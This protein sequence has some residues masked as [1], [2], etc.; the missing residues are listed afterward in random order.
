MLLVHQQLAQQQAARQLITNHLPPHSVPLPHGGSPHGQP[1]RESN[2]SSV[3]PMGRDLRPP[4]RD[5]HQADRVVVA[6]SQQTRPGSVHAVDIR[7]GSHHPH[8]PSQASHHLYKRTT[9]VPLDPREHVQQQPPLRIETR[10]LD[11]IKRV[12]IGFN[13]NFFLLPSFDAN[14]YVHSIRDGY[15]QLEVISICLKMSK[16]T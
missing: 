8:E 7:G 12:S 9:R 11:T 3:P 2:S 5:H 4:S 15:F 14:Y 10:D 1:H 13:V 16:N 6:Q